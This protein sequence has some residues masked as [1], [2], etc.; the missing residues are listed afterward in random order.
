MR[1]LASSTVGV[2]NQMDI[3]TSLRPRVAKPDYLRYFSPIRRYA[4]RKGS[5]FAR[6]QRI[7]FFGDMMRGVEFDRLGPETHALDSYRHDGGG[8][9]GSFGAA[10][11]L[12]LLSLPW[13]TYR[14]R[15]SWRDGLLGGDRSRA[16]VAQRLARPQASRSRKSR[17]LQGAAVGAI[18][19][20]P[21]PRHGDAVR[22][23]RGREPVRASPRTRATCPEADAR[24]LLRRAWCRRSARST[25]R[26]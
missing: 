16:R 13:W 6:H 9:Q 22:R 17:K 18:A 1:L 8:C 5:P 19:V 24:A 7:G 15:R 26:W 21:P 3:R 14:A 12:P 11:L 25:L 23:H 2:A 10:G 4:S 20:R